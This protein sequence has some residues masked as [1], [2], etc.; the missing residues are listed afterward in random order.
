[1]AHSKMLRAPRQFRRNLRDWGPRVA[2][3]KAYAKVWSPIHLHRVYRV[4]RIDLQKWQPRSPLADG[5]E[6]AVSLLLDA[7]R[8][9]AG[10]VLTLTTLFDR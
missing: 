6:E 2:L 3:W 4:Y 9:R 10:P 1:M 5:L 8:R 7:V